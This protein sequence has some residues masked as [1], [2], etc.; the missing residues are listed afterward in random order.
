[1]D[2]NTI[3]LT[4]KTSLSDAFFYSDED[5]E[6]FD[7]WLHE[8]LSNAGLFD[9][10]F[11]D[12]PTDVPG[13]TKLTGYVNTFDD[14]HTIDIYIHVD[15][16]V[17]SGDELADND[18]LFNYIERK[19]AYRLIDELNAIC[20]NVSFPMN[21]GSFRDLKF[22]DGEFYGMINH[23]GEYGYFISPRIQE[24]QLQVYPDFEAAI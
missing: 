23:S 9:W 19:L 24:S 7:E 6:N 4:I 2:W 3:A 14:D 8:K 13:I 18:A 17:H 5:N 10:E 1:M 12:L 15:D 16:D 20:G 22:D 11:E 21:N